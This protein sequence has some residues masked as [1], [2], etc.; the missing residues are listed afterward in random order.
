MIDI[1]NLQQSAIRVIIQRLELAHELIDAYISS[2]SFVG[3]T[4]VQCASQ[5][6]KSSS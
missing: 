1:N 2:G 6:L 4:L 3:L 5:Q